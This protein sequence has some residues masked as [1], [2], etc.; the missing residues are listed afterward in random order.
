[1]LRPFTYLVLT[2][3]LCFSSNGQEEAKPKPVRL[4]IP[5]SILSIKERTEYYGMYIQENKVGWMRNT[6]KR[7]TYEGQDAFVIE[8]EGKQSVVSAGETL[9]SAFI[10]REYF[11]TEPPYEV[12][13][14][15]HVMKQGD[16]ENTVTVKCDDGKFKSTLEAGGQQTKMEVDAGDYT[17]A[18]MAGGESWCLSEPMA[19]DTLLLR[20]MDWEELKVTGSKQTITEVIEG[21]GDGPRYRIDYE[22]EDGHDSGEFIV[23]RAGIMLSARM[24]GAIDLRKE[25][26]EAA[27]TLKGGFDVFEAALLRIDQPL[28]NPKTIIELEMEASGEGAKLI[29]SGGMQTVTYDEATE[30]ARL[31]IVSKPAERERASEEEIDEALRSTVSVPSDSPEIQELALRAVKGAKSKRAKVKRLVNFVDKFIIDDMSA[32]PPTVLDLIETRRGD[33]TEHSD[34]FVTLARSLGIPARVVNGF[35]YGEDSLLSF[36][37]HAWCEVVVDGKWYAVDPTWGETQPNA[38]HV[39]VSSGKGGTNDLKVM[40]G[41]L[42]LKI[43]SSTHKKGMGLS[44]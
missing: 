28:G 29:P 19:G 30:T 26:A 37:G 20:E 10:D 22:S 13:G 40:L 21:D 1:M 11:S 15:L 17:F 9:E 7:G 12:L 42:K 27:M 25:E 44:R 18:D 8:L 16:F 4:P 34:L 23:N 41:G 3:A 14:A 24:G 43:I 39:R 35:I 2:L 6:V 38:T 31:K 36:G 32:E 33:C 5:E